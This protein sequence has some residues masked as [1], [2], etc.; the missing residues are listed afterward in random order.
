MAGR[1][2][3]TSRRSG[4]PAEPR[5]ELSPARGRRS[6]A[7]VAI[8][9]NRSTEVRTRR[10]PGASTRECGAPGIYGRFRAHRGTKIGLSRMPPG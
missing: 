2:A 1:V 5:S 4:R 7:A 10:G 3:E 9:P 8:A 6:D